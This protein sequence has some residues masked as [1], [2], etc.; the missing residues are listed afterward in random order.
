MK[1]A[2]ETMLKLGRYKFTISS[3]SYE[4]LRQVWRFNWQHSQRAKGYPQPQFTGQG[5]RNITL[6]GVIYPTEFG[7]PN[8][9]QEMAVSAAE[10]L[11]LQMFSGLG[12][13]LGWWAV[14]SIERADSNPFAD[15]QARK[16]EF[17]ISLTYYGPRYDG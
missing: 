7:T 2:P 16:V 8:Q 5:A 3:I 1:T 10:G 9:L 12:Q 14:T 4:K 13:M 15:G 17:S 11:P 6:S